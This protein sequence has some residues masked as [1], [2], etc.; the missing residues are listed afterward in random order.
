[1][2]NYTWIVLLCEDRQHEVFMRTFL[3]GHGVPARRMRIKIASKGI[4]SAE[5]FVRNQYSRIPN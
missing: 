1:M 2:Y 4:G 3:V 5:Q